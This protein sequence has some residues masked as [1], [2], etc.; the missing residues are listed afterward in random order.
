MN[1]QIIPEAWIE[2]ST[3]PHSHT[4]QSHIGYGYMW[5]THTEGPLLGL[6]SALG[7]GGHAI[8]VLPGADLVFAHRM[9]TDKKNH[10][11]HPQHRQLLVEILKAHP[12]FAD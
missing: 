11:Q 2:E 1:Q 8:D 12:D 9:D 6:I 5:W 3:R 7:Y 4:P 10:I